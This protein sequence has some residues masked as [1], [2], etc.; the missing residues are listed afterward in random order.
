MSKNNINGKISLSDF[1]LDAKS[2]VFYH[3]KSHMIDYSDGVK[4]EGYVLNAIKNSEDIS[5]HSSEL[6]K[7]VKDWPSYYHLGTGR[8]NIFNVLD[9]SE[10]SKVLE[11]GCG[12]GAITR[13]LGETFE[14]VDAVDGSPFR[15][16]ITRE[17]C[18]DLN[19]VNVYCSNVSNIK[20]SASYDIVTAIGVLEYAPVYYDEKIAPRDSCMCLLKQLKSALKTSGL[21]IVGIENKIGLK[22]WSGSP[23]DHTGK[24][25]D[26]IQDYPDKGPITFSKREIES[27]LKDAGFSNISF[28]YCFPDYKFASTIISDR[29]DGRGYYLHNWIEIPFKSQSI[30]RNYNFHEGL[31][32]KTLSEAGL[33]KEFANSFLIIASKDDS[34]TLSPEW[35]IRKI[36]VNR[37]DE[38]KCITTLNT[39]PMRVE[40]KRMIGTDKDV[41]LENN[42]IKI[43]HKVGTRKWEEGNLMIFNVYKSLFK[44]D[45]KKEILDILELYYN[46]LTIN[47]SEMVDD[48]G[49]PFLKETDIDYTIGNLIESHDDLVF[50]DNEFDVDHIPADYVFYRCIKFNI[51]ECNDYFLRKKIVNTDKFIIE[52]IKNFFPKYNKKRHKRNKHLEESFQRLIDV[53][54][55]P[56]SFDGF[57]L[58]LMQKSVQILPENVKEYLKT[59]YLR[60]IE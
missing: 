35:I 57:S 34:K 24:V 23:E 47:Y 60:L 51:V 38:F 59:I 30:S 58:S 36:S 54:Y 6:I 31:A 11:L 9:L 52:L 19:N 56:I 21:L 41:I 10:N 26:S 43:K 48:E 27:L 33:L 25:F 14:K 28:L 7:W 44:D 49:Y 42:G 50:I 1:Q 5:N 8:S 12:C 4:N 46:K 17:R 45:W 22:Y 3:E 2:K 37:K 53:G 15:A 29:G 40:K 18:K 16:R 13:Y 20:F 32:I 55:P 39:D